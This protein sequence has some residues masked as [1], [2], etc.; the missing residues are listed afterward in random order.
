MELSV[1]HN[2]RASL[3]YK[4]ALRCKAPLGCQLQDGVRR[5]GDHSEMSAFSIAISLDRCHGNRFSVDIQA[6]VLSFRQSAYPS[7]PDQIQGPVKE[8]HS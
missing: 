3:C 7:R 4:S 2:P 1:T 6:R 8:S 5:V